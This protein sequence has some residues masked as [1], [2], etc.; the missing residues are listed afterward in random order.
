MAY[1]RNARKSVVKGGLKMAGIDIQKDGDLVRLTPSKSCY[2]TGI[3]ATER[4]KTIEFQRCH[5]SNSDSGTGNI[6]EVPK[7]NIAFINKNDYGRIIEVG[8]KSK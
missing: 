7:E 8:V 3:I 6:V 2:N 4:I 5:E 1:D